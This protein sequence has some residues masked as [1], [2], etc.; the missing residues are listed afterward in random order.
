MSPRTLLGNQQ[1]NCHVGC[2]IHGAVWKK[3][4][5]KKEKEASGTDRDRDTDTDLDMDTDM[6]TD[7]DTDMDTETDTD[8]DM[9]LANFS[10]RSAVRMSHVISWRKFQGRYELVAH[11]S[12]E[13]DDMQIHSAIRTAFWTMC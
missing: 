7:T 6:D 5:K 13:N 2:N 3:R 8:S 9:K 4:I 1:D 11:F 10:P 12:N